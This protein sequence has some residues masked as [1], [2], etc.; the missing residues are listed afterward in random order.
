[1]DAT[2]AALLGSS[3]GALAAVAGSVITNV[4]TVNE[5]PPRG[6]S[7]PARQ[8]TRRRYAEVGWKIENYCGVVSAARGYCLTMRVVLDSSAADHLVDPPEA[9]EAVKAAIESGQIELLLPA[10]AR[11]EL[12]R[13]EDP[14]QRAKLMALAELCTPVMDGGWNIGEGAFGQFRFGDEVA[15]ATLQ[16]GNRRNTADAVIAAACRFE[17]ATLVTA[18]DRQGRQAQRLMTW[19]W[20][21][22]HLLQRVGYRPDVPRTSAERR[23]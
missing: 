6:S 18:D 3:I 12:S 7:S 15:I 11:R 8:A 13:T 20:Q 1:M 5:R 16:Q 19:V 2:V 17:G 23:Q 9:F 10:M 21:P 4:V 22:E 14:E